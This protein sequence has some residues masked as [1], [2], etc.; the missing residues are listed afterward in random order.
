MLQELPVQG[1][2]VSMAAQR[3]AR[4]FKEFWT[5]TLHRGGLKGVFEPQ[6]MRGIIGAMGMI[7]RSSPEMSH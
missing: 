6:Y 4:V 1:E 5:S 3:P 7:L 2:Y